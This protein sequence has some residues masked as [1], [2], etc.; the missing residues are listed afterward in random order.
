MIIRFL[1]LFL[2]L[3]AKM[4]F[5][6]CEEAFFLG[7]DFSSL[8][9]VEAAGAV[10]L[11]NGQAIDPMNY[12][13]SQGA[14]LARVRLLHTP[15]WT[16]ACGQTNQFSGLDDVIATITRA[17]ANGMQVMLNFHYSDQPTNFNY[18]QVPQS[19]VGISNF[20][21]LQ[22]SIY[23]YTFG[24]LAELAALDLFPEFVQV[25]NAIDNGF[26]D[27]YTETTGM[28]WS[29]SAPLL[30][31]ASKAVRDAGYIF[32]KKVKIV[33]HLSQP[34]NTEAWLDQALQF[35]LTNFD[36]IGLSYFPQW[37][38][39][40]IGEIGELV[41]LF[42]YKFKREVMITET[43]F[44]W[45]TYWADNYT[46]LLGEASSQHD[47]F[48]VSPQGQR[49][50][51]LQ[52]TQTVIADGGSGV[53]YW[54]PAWVPTDACTLGGQGSAYENATLFDFFFGNTPTAAVDF[55]NQAYEYPNQVRFKVNME[56]QAIDKGVFVT[57]TFTG[58]DWHFQPMQYEGN[59]TFSYQ[60]C[61]MPGELSV[62][63]YYNGTT[64]A[65][66]EKETIPADCAVGVGNLRLFDLGETTLDLNYNY[67]SCSYD[68]NPC[69]ELPDGMREGNVG[70]PAM[71]GK[72]CFDPESNTFTIGGAGLRLSNFRDDFYYTWKMEN[73]DVGITAK[74]EQISS[75]HE[76]AF[77]ALMI[78]ASFDWDAS[79]AMTF[80]D[81]SGNI[82]LG[83]R[84]NGIAF[85]NS[86][87]VPPNAKWL[88][89]HRYDDLFIAYYSTDGSD[90][91]AL[92]QV[93]IT[94][95]DEVHTGMAVHSHEFARIN[96]A[97]FSNVQIN[98]EPI[99][100][101]S[102][103]EEFLPEDFA[104]IYPNPVSEILYIEAEED[105]LDIQL[106]DSQGRLVQQLTSQGLVQK[107][108]CS[109]LSTGLYLVKLTDGVL[110]K[111]YQ[112]VKQ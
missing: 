16:N 103:E 46:N 1:L 101:T 53:L 93:T 97:E 51:L 38:V 59:Y 2:L 15:N 88:H 6:Q 8:T 55:Y 36:I 21:A 30:N 5:A 63:A 18:Q 73:G 95:P 111:S 75:T 80:M 94:M 74:I 82:G 90:W 10:F 52:L 86:Y 92:D 100:L 32:N 4:L 112:F 64:W 14:E 37:S 50:F 26:C 48:S 67:G 25:G 68:E 27:D 65:A 33:Y 57:G 28:N 31:E 13:A 98:E 76:E 44:P 34:A 78:R 24:V 47:Y 99:V 69:N 43:G 41:R 39:K 109:K 96:V 60:T 77:A 89:L 19:W 83:G 17:K 106:F 85:R 58:T 56:D 29:R 42:K 87:P 12:L 45:T 107:I 84:V 22:D 23:Q 108:D 54:E 7:A 62:Y 35:H 104:N 40:S 81:P 20:K 71:R 70:V 72:A 102:Q 11:E 110:W 3:N 61:L 9:Q 49:Q 66:E 105:E 91:I 79:Y